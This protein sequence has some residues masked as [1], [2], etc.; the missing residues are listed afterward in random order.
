MKVSATTPDFL[1][2]V[3]LLPVVE[4]DAVVHVS[5]D[6]LP[7]SGNVLS[8]YSPRVVVA[9]VLGPVT[10]EGFHK[11]PERAIVTELACFLAL[12]KD[13][14]FTGEQ[15]RVALRPDP[16]QELADGTMRTYLSM[17]RKALGPA[18]EL[19]AEDGYQLTVVHSDWESFRAAS[20]PEADTLSR[21]GALRFVRGRPFEDVGRGTYRWVFAELWI[22]TMEV[23]IVETALT[24][25]RDLLRS[26][27]LNGAS[28]A[29]HQ[30]LLGAPHDLSL[31]ALL[32]EVAERQGVRALAT[33][34]A[35]AD[36]ALGSDVVES[37]LSD[38]V[39]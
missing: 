17:L 32:L 8:A 9:K 34:R 4:T 27:D 33:T 19:R 6:D 30:G 38:P 2:S 23:A 1:E 24:V 21:M 22:S 7:A 13:R 5:S 25:A 26:G 14:S 39:A 36:A 31:W 12:H 28:W 37:L 20:G 11:S 3:A 16:T 35:Q 15:L 10:V 18:I 29:L